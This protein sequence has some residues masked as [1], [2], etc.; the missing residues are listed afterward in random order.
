MSV[1]SRGAQDRHGALW[2]NPV[3]LNPIREALVFTA[4]RWTLIANSS[5]LNAES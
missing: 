3:T 4:D 1:R 2:L 5:S